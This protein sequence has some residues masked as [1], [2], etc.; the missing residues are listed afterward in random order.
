MRQEAETRRASH[1]NMSEGVM[2]S[3][4]EGGL[5]GGLTPLNML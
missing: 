2:E 5:I 1:V 3:T 4:A